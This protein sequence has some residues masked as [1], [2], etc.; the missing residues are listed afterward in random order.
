MIPTEI[1]PNFVD[2]LAISANEHNQYTSVPWPLH[3]YIR[4]FI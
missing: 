3:P 1:D 4:L 2:A